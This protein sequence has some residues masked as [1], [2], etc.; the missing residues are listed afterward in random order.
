MARRIRVRWKVV[1][2]LVA[3]T[4]FG[5]PAAANAAL[6][7]N[8]PPSSNLGS[9]STG[10]SSKTA[11]LGTVTVTASGLVAPSF[12]A[13]V[14]TT[15]FTTGGGSANETIQKSSISYWSGP[16]TTAVGTLSVTPGQANAGAA[17]T[18]SVA[19]TA[20]SAVGLLLS[21]TVAWNP[22]LIVNIPS[23]AVAGTYTGTI[24]HSVA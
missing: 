11:Q 21:I 22:T 8:V 10:S 16:H 20:F 15:V 13:T 9:T 14:T 24:T 4:V 23:S 7:I 17:Q 3:L 6:A 12:I 19:R 2:A 1:S 5:F 18:L